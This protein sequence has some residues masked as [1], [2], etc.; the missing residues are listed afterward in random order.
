MSVPDGDPTD[1]TAL[2]ALHPLAKSEVELTPTLR[3]RETYTQRGLHTVL[4][5]EP[6]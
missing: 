2:E 1:P 5:H 3:H 6:A 4:W